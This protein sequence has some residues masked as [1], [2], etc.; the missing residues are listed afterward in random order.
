MII[1]AIVFAI[2]LNSSANTFLTSGNTPEGV[3]VTEC[4]PEFNLEEEAYIDD[5]PFDTECVS[6]NCIYQKAIAEN[7]DFEEEASIN[8]IPFE[9]E[10][11]VMINE[12]YFEDES[13]IDDIPFD[14]KKIVKQNNR[15]HYVYNR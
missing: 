5:I 14:T 11:I 10:K 3:L 8:D 7:F 1:L 12:Y 15:N 9:T 6:K 13:Y 2:S 4:I